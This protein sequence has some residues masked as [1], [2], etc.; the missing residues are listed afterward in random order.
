MLKAVVKFHSTMILHYS[1]TSASNWSMADEFHSTMILHYSQ[2]NQKT[3][4]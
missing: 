2:T 3:F 4:I 1:Q